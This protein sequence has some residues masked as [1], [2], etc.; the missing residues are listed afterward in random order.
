MATH[1][2]FHISILEISNMGG[3]SMSVNYMCANAN[4]RL[5]SQDL[6]RR[7][8]NQISG[9]QALIPIESTPKGGE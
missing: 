9:A 7:W 1:P 5:A 8:L 6:T 3:T 4:D 2:N